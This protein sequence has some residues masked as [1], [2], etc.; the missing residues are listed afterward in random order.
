MYAKG[1]RCTDC[2]NPH[3]AKVK[4]DGN[5][6]CTSCHMDTHPAGKYDTASHHYHKA[7]GTGALCVECHMP[8]STYMMVDPRRDHSFKVP[9]P[10]LSLKYGTPNNCTRCHLDRA[11]IAQDRPHGP[12]DYQAWI[13]AAR[14]GDEEARQALREIDQW[15]VDWMLKWYGDKWTQQPEYASTFTAA[16]ADDPAAVRGLADLARD[17]QA[18]AM[19][20]AT[21][22]HDLSRFP[23][24][25]EVLQ[26]TLRS[27]KDPSPQVR[28]AAIATL[29][30]IIRRLSTLLHGLRASDPNVKAEARRQLA[31]VPKR[32]LLR[33]LKPLLCD[34]S[35][36]VRTDAAR[37]LATLP[38]GEFS[39]AE[40]EALE[41]DFKELVV[42]LDA[43]SDQAGAHTTLASIYEQSGKWRKAVDCYRKAI[44]VQGD[45]VGPRSNLAALLDQLG[46]KDEAKQLR[47]EELKLLERDVR[48]LKESGQENAAL[49]YR[50]GMSLYLHDRFDEAEQALRRAFEL[51]PQT[52]DFAAALTLFYE[53]FERWDEAI[54]YCRK[55][56]ELH[57]HD[58]Q[59]EQ[60]LKNLERR[61]GQE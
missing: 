22:V 45:V 41:K 59:Y 20:R 34:P 14:E 5:K 6:L 46:E 7:D 61:A 43:N 50:L 8:E 44:F 39:S 28:A 48:L 54:T 1:V 12:L 23:L 33:A 40:Q 10:D 49:L 30:P 42:S 16:W 27:L 36:L 60:V 19:I 17:K 15:S 25:D 24:D 3:T 35:R 29:E 18:P 53:K 11:E 38:A 52:P 37:L 57:P 4:Y 51:E 21:A 55:Y 56:L 2:H 31:S 9:R 58:R 13:A 47:R 32:S 26:T